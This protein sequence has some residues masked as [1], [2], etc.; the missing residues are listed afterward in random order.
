MADQPPPNRETWQAAS[1][2]RGAA[3][4][5]TML[6]EATP[7]LAPD[8]E[9]RVREQVVGA[10]NLLREARHAVVMDRCR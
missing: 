6:L 4:S 2:A 5:L 9:R 7:A 8:V 3:S 10:L 1:E